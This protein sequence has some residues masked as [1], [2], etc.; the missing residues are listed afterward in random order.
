MFDRGATVVEVLVERF[1][2]RIRREPTTDYQQMPPIRPRPP[3]TLEALAK[4]EAKIGFQLPALLRLLYTEIGDGG[5]GPGRGLEH[6]DD[7]EWSLVARAERTCVEAA[8]E[9]DA[10]WPPRLVEFVSWGGHYTSCV[11]CSG[12]PYSVWFYDHDRNIDGATQ[13]DYLLFQAESLEGFL[14]EWLDGRDLW[15]LVRSRHAE[16]GAAAERGNG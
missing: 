4:A 16:P 12:S 5:Y 3:V 10:W 11:D 7:N 14:K 15:V 2:E 1:R 8:A 6:L 13:T 9:G